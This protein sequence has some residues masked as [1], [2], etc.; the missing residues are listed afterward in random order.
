MSFYTDEP[1]IVV[2]GGGTG[3]SVLLKGLKKHT[4]QLTAVVTVSDDGGSSGR[5]RAELGILPPG[6]IRNCLVALAET[7]TLMDKVFQHRFA[8]G[9][10]I[11]G[12]NLGNLLLLAMTEITG[13]FVSA[14]KEVSE[15]LAVRGKVIPATL[16]QVVLE[17]R[18]KD[19]AIVTGETAIRNYNHKIEK[20]YLVPE[21]CRPVP[22]TLNALLE[23]DAIIMGPGSLYT[24]I[25]PN[26]LVEGVTSA[27]ARSKAVKIYI[28][29][30]MTEQGETDDFTALDHLR[31]IMDYVAEPIIDYIILNTG[32]IDELRLKRYQEEKAVPVADS[33]Q[34][35]TDLGIKVMAA[36]LVSNTEVAWHDPDKLANIIMQVIYDNQPEG[37]K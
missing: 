34:Q 13:D 25:I 32:S 23:A 27:I 19:G 35:I 14:I 8:Q 24:S 18:M 4:S 5:L 12:H 15:V 9:S 26:L 28:S 29:N 37:L 3:L 30:I 10:G 2:I 1:K 7:E 36:D 20:I 22:D 16:D 6:D 33:Y 11:A 17:A 31:V 21:A